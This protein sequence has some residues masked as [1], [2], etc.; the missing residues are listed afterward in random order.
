M[1]LLGSDLVLDEP[2]HPVQGDPPVIP[3]D[4]PSAVC[5][6][7]AGDDACVPGT[8]HIVGVHVKYPIVVGLPVFEYVF[9]IRGQFSAVGCQGIAHHADTAEGHNGTLQRCVRLQAHNG[10]QFFVD[11]AAFVGGDGG[12]GV[13][14]NIQHAS[15]LPLLLQQGEHLVPQRPGT[16][17]GGRKKA[18]VPFI[19]CIV[20]DDKVPQIDLL[21]PDAAFEFHG[22]LLVP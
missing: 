7:Q 4:A 22:F 19:G 14:V 6:R 15:C 13:L 18:V 1:C 5:V 8:L 12:N 3:D 9:H 20:L 11:V 21:V 17:S 2:I 16:G 10:F